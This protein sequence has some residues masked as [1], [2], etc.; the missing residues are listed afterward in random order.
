[1]HVDVKRI[2]CDEIENTNFC[3]VPIVSVAV[4]HSEHHMHLSFHIHSR[5]HLPSMI[6]DN[7]TI[8]GIDKFAAQNSGL[9]LN[10]VVGSL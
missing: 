8:A 5:L 4:P 10:S 1:M 7:M 6:L 3:F 9:L 2:E